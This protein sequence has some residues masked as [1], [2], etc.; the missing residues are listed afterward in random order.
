MIVAIGAVLFGIR[1]GHRQS[2]HA[3]NGG[4][5]DGGEKP[6]T[7]GLKTGPTEVG[8]TSGTIDSIRLNR[9]KVRAMEDT[10]KDA[11]ASVSPLVHFRV[12][13]PVRRIYYGL[14]I[15]NATISWIQV[16]Y[17]FLLRAQPG[18]IHNSA[19]HFIEINRPAMFFIIN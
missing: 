2:S 16:V 6:A 9:N 3:Q 1:K 4:D 11:M 19:L 13:T 14:K 7:K 10:K 12:L 8:P 5:A 15:I 18:S 17:F